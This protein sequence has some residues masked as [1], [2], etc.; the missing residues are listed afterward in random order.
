MPFQ[1]RKT[2]SPAKAVRRVSRERISVARE[3]LREGGHAAA[4]HDVRREIKKLRAILR[5]AREAVGR[6]RYR[7]SV[8]ALR[9]AAGYL[10]GPRDARVMLKTFEQLT[11]GDRRHFAEIEKIL[12]KHCRRQTRR[13]HRSKSVSI[14]DRILRKIN[15]RMRGLKIEASGWS[16]IE[17]GLKESYVRGVKASVLVHRKPMPENFHD[18]R[19]H[20]KNLWYYFQLLRPAWPPELRTMTDDLELL[21][22][23]LGED[24][25]LFLLEQFVKRNCAKQKQTAALNQLIESR[26]EK[27][28][29]A[30]LKLGSRLYT[31]SPSSLCRRLENHWNLWRGK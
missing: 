1:F 16:A 27:L 6:G 22:G 13:F 29:E 30:T 4:I 31:E 25:D 23:Q 10:A 21:G 15:R 8:R 11:G 12:Q 5:L 17:P 20:V 7:K 2:E 3:R 26:Q 24:H 18:W 9:E 28:R 14:A 19:K